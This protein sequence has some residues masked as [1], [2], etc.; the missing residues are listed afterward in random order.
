MWRQIWRG[1]GNLGRRERLTNLLRHNRFRQGNS[2][3][4]SYDFSLFSLLFSTWS[5]SIP[6]SNLFFF[7]WENSFET[8]SCVFFLLFYFPSGF[9]GCFYF[10]SL[11]VLFYLFPFLPS[12][13]I[14]LLFSFPKLI[15]LSTLISYFLLLFWPPSLLTTIYFPT[16]HFLLLF[17]YLC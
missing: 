15:H 16:F 3:F 12:S 5:S 10:H 17:N 7:S 13:P 1:S 2:I 6:F 11:S 14:S 4:H 9:I 8:F